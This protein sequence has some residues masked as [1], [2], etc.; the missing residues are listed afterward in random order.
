MRCKSNIIGIRPIS[1]IYVGEAGNTLTS[2]VYIAS[3]V[4]DGQEVGIL[5]FS[6]VTDKHGSERLPALA[7][8]ANLVTLICT[9]IDAAS[10]CQLC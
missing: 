10:L 2:V 3:L 4:S 9:G 8:L 7:Y 1:I 6:E 5:S